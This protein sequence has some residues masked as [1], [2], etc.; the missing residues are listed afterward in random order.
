MH[1]EY[2]PAQ[3]ARFWA[4]LPHRPADGCWPSSI[5][6]HF[7]FGVR[8]YR[9][10]WEI[11]AG[12][13]PNG[14]EVCHVCDYT[15]CCRNDEPGI[16][17]IDGIARP[18]FGHLWLGTHRENLRDMFLKGRNYYGRVP[19]KLQ[20]R[21]SSHGLARL[22]EDLVRQILAIPPGAMMQSEMA[23]MFH[24]SQSQISRI[25]SGLHWKHVT[26]S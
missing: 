3:M 25:R 17:V 14:F 15:P 8:P 22:N 16:Y 10:A 24:V 11:V 1:V 4:S 2:T 19:D 7:G 18:R 5:K 21:G 13:V 20:P 12:P 9:M 6:R 26:G 23:D